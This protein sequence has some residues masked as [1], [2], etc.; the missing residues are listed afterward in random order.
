M[1]TTKDPQLTSELQDLYLENKGWLADVYFLEDETRF[2]NKLLND[3]FLPAIKQNHLQD[4]Q[5]VQK[6]LQTL[7]ER[8]AHLKGLIEKNQQALEASMSAPD[9]PAGLGLLEDSAQIQQE[10]R[11]L[12][13]A[14]NSIKRDLFDLVEEVMHK[15]KTLHLLD[16]Q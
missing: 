2:I 4:M 14:D 1:K 6:K 9:Y 5:A 10:I 12:L 13:K 3:Y 8:R 15:E 16:K 7:V 11:A